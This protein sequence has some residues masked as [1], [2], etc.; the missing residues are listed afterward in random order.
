MRIAALDLGSNSFH[1]LVA[2]VHPDG[3]FEAVA[4][5]KEMLRLGDDVTRN[6]R[7]SPPAA[8]R[9]VATVRR[10]KQLADALGATEVL[11][12][13][14]SALRTAANGS[15]LVDRIEDETGVEVEVISG[16]EEARLIFAA[17]RASVVIDPA[18]ALGIDI[19][20]GSVEFTIGDA[21][22]LR[23]AESVPLGVGRLTAEFVS[24]DPPSKSERKRLEDH[25]RATLEP[26]LPDV[27]S[28]SPRMCVGTSGTIND[29]ARMTDRDAD[30][31]SSDGL[32]RAPGGPGG[33]ARAERSHPPLEDRRA[34]A[35]AR[36]RREARRAAAGGLDAARHR[37]RPL[38]RRDA[39][40]Q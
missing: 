21:A 34:P 37:A 27:V 17:V 9:A 32:E 1:L 28:R 4:R 12:K 39:H 38:R 8:D 20:G 16:L 10:L 5:E 11:A 23:W 13:A 19:G 29:L 35:D 31:R 25:I 36:A 24:D 7:I 18:P 3:T 26:L 22:G 6:D 15:E 2:D 14:T 30:R 40:D 33:A